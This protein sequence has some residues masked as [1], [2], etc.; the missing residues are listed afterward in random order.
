MGRNGHAAIRFRTRA[1]RD[2]A[3]GPPTDPCATAG[4]RGDRACT[5]KLKTEDPVFVHRAARARA[6]RALGHYHYLSVHALGFP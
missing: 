1:H 4:G 3:S 5:K 2:I 6:A